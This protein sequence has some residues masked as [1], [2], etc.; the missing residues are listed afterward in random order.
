MAN[1]AQYDVIVNVITGQ[2]EKAIKELKSVGTSVEGV[3]KSQSKA[4]KN[5]ENFSKALGTGAAGANSATRSFTKLRD[6]IGNGNSGIV[7]AYATLAINAYAVGAA[8]TALREAEQ[9]NLLLQGLETQGARTGLAL[10]LTAEAVRDITGSAISSADAMKATAQFSAA[11]FN[12]DQLKAVT[13]VAT[14]ASKALGRNLPDSL[15]RLIKGTSKL[16][17]ELLDELGLMTKLSEATNIYALENNK[18]ASSLTSMEKRQA[19]L[20]AVLAEGELKFGGISDKVKASPY[21]KLAGS[22][23]NLTKGVLNFINTSL[24]AG[25]FIGF[26]SQNSLALVSVLTIFAG[27]ISRQLVPSLYEVSAASEAAS[28]AIAKKIAR[29]K[30]AIDITLKQANAEKKLREKQATSSKV[31][32]VGSPAKVTAYITALKENNTVEGQR[33]SALKSVTG[34]IS[35]HTTLLKKMTDQESEAALVKKKLIADLTNQKVV[36]QTLTTAELNHANIVGNA[37]A[38]LAKLRQQTAVLK[39]QDEAQIS[40]ANAVQLAG[41]FDFQGTIQKSQEAM[42]SYKQSV[43]IVTESKVAAA[44]SGGL[45]NKSIALS[46]QVAGTAK[47]AFFNLSLGIRVVGAALLNAIPIIGQVLFAFSLLTEA[48]EA[49]F[50]TAESKRKEKALEDLKTVTDN[51]SKAIEEYN[52]LTTTT[53]SLAGRTQALLTNQ[54]NSALELA[55]AYQ[56]AFAKNKQL[57][58]EAAK[59]KATPGQPSNVG[60]GVAAKE[61]GISVDSVGIKA[62]AEE[63][64]Y[65]GNTGVWVSE[66]LGIFTKEVQ[67]SIKALDQAQSIAPEL[68]EEFIKLNG[69]VSS[70]SKLSKEAREQKLAE[71]MG[72]IKQ[73][74]EFVVPAVNSVTEAFK[75]AETASTEFLRSAIQTTPFDAMVTSLTS[76]ND[77]LYELNAVSI[78]AK[79]SVAL[80]TSIGA[81]QQQFLT[82]DNSK[83]IDSIR[84]ADN[85]VQKLNARVASG[86][87]LNKT[88][89]NTLEQQKLILGNSKEQLPAIKENLRT[90]EELFRSA[91]GISRQSQAQLSLVQ[92]IMN[93]NAEAYSAGAAGMRAKIAGEEKIMA[94]QAAGLEAQKR[95]IDASLARQRIALEELRTTQERV[96]SQKNLTAATEATGLAEAKNRAAQFGITKDNALAIA[97]AP[98]Q[99]TAMIGTRESLTLPSGKSEDAIAAARALLAAENTVIQSTKEQDIAKRNVEVAQKAINDREAESLSIQNQISAIYATKLTAAEK[100]AEIQKAETIL[101]KQETDLVTKNTK[102]KEDSQAAI[103]KLL[104]TTLGSADSL[105]TKLNEISAKYASDLAES[106]SNFDQEIAVLSSTLDAQVKRAAAATGLDKIAFQRLVE[107]TRKIKT[108]R[109][110]EK[111]IADQILETARAQQQLDLIGLNTIEQRITREKEALSFIQAQVDANKASMEAALALRQSQASLQ[112]KK[113]GYN[114]SDSPVLTRQQEIDAAQ[115]AYDIVKNEVDIKTTLLTLE[116]GLLEAKRKQ[117]INDIV[118]AKQALEVRKQEAL[119]MGKSPEVI[120]ALETDIASASTILTS[121]GGSIAVEGGKVITSYGEGFNKVLV[122]G[123]KALKSGVEEAGRKLQTTQERGPRVQGGFVSD[124]KLAKDSA[125]AYLAQGASTTDIITEQMDAQ[126]SKVKASLQALGPQGEIVLAIAEGASLMTKSFQDLGTAIAEGDFGSKVSA[127]LQV[128]SAAI[129]TI[130]NILKASSD[131]KIANIDKEIAAEEKRDGKSLGS[132]EKINALEKRKITIAKKSFDT[133]KKLQMAMVVIQT[134][135]AAISIAASLAQIPAGAGLPFIPAAVG[136]LVA[137]GAAQLALIAGTSYDGGGNVSAAGGVSNISIG[138]RSDTVDL[139]KGPSASAGGEVGYL[140][141]AQGTGSNASNY[142]TVGSAYGGELMRGY[143]NRGFVVGE[144]GPEVITPETPISVTPANDTQGSA[145][146]N[147]TFNIQALDSSDVQRILVEQKGNIITMLR[148]AAN[149]SGKTFMEDVNTNVYTRPNIGKL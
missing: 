128:A 18:S 53:A 107:N 99:K 100:A 145:P 37:E 40:R 47:I 80:I 139:A 61:L 141:G 16:E 92:A 69:G 88:D 21:D 68:T 63:V 51:T 36:L 113:G 10:T 104:Q 84:L 123:I 56:E 95:I 24:G 76:L 66:K 32:V 22:F 114:I 143:G 17:P 55:N 2:L 108:A 129:A 140:R 58:E 142:R 6:T 77:S 96:I 49:V 81:S 134:A 89:Q 124:Y 25:S 48:Y 31:T 126:I 118:T 86:E 35:R 14:D 30:E 64:E 43:N 27:T 3:A 78:T 20:N 102:L 125:A 60:A 29:Q 42:K 130:G 132:V 133:Q 41:E 73:R 94:L 105:S 38:K 28:A 23:D 83:L 101:V 135:V 26:L 54:A 116:F 138:K 65:L 33:E 119:K 59:T 121:L 144:K 137:I 57:N 62:Y 79:D 44:A 112:A 131:A 122:A 13:Q 127:G 15:D 85:I 46:S 91:Q 52:R 148:Q 70:F 97:S 1:S 120:A 90:N 4:T 136:M 5:S 115:T 87:E 34:A 50:S 74:F 67:A 106:T 8:F 71:L 9:V 39:K 103:Q 45:L 75:A 93:K 111:A 7:G 117:S 110:A 146:V 149:A 19:F 98:V 147:A 11:G 82:P 109:E 12:T 72:K